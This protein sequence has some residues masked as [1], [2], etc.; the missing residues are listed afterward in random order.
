MTFN[1][2]TSNEIHL[3]PIGVIHSPFHEKTQTPIQPPRS[4]AEGWVEVFAEDMDGLDDQ[5]HGLFS[6]RKLA[7]AGTPIAPRVKQYPS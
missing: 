7:A 1:P 4:T 5:P 3:R 6:T 2:T